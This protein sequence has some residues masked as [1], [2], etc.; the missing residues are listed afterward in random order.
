MTPLEKDYYRIL[1]VPASATNEQIK[2]QY[3]KLAK[4]YHPDARI[5]DKTADHTPNADVFRDVVEAY[6]VLSVRESRVNYDLQRRKNPDLF[7][8]MSEFEFNLE[9][10]RD[11]RDKRG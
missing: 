8:G 7:K 9:H 10:R 4:K 5:A 3:R 2:D 1:N 11:F 6:Q